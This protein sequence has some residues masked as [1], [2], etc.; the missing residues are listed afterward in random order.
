MTATTATGSQFTFRDDEERQ[1]AKVL[2]ARA[3][4]MEAK[5]VDHDVDPQVQA[6]ADTPLPTDRTTS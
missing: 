4:V 5:F 1:V 2:L 3:L 6:D